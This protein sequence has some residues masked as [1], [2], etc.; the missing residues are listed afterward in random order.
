M[1]DAEQYS[2][3]HGSENRMPCLGK[4]FSISERET[5]V[6]TP[7]GGMVFI[8]IADSI[9]SG[10][11]I[12]VDIKG[13]VDTPYYDLGKTTAE[14][15]KVAKDA[16]GVFAEIRTPYL[17][18]I[19]PT[20]F[21]RHIED[22]QKAAEFWTNVTALS[23]TAMGLENRTTPM[24]M[25]FDQY[26][27]VGIAYANVWGWSCN[28]PPE[29]AK[30][31]FDY[32]G[33]VKNGSWG[34]IHEINHHYQR[35]Y[36]NYSDEWGLGTDFTEITN[37][38]LSAAS[39]ILY[40]NIAASRGEEGTYD[41]N[42]VADP[43]SSL[44][45]QIY[46]GVQYYPGVP[47]IGNFMFS[48]FAHEIG[49]INYVNVIKSTY[50]GGTFNG[51]YIPPYDYRLESQG[52]LKRDD[53]YDDMAYR[54]CM[55]GGRD[56]TWYIQ[57]ELRW[58]L[59]QETV[60]A[61][62]DLGYKETIPVQ[63]VYAMGEVGRETGRPFYIPSSGYTFDF[64]KSLVSPGDVTVVD[65]S[66]TK[67][68]TLQL[69]PD[70]K[71]DYL[72]STS[73]P[74]NA[75]DEFVLTVKVEQD[76]IS[77]ETKLNC[78][79]ALDYNASVVEHFDILKWDIYEAL[80][81]LPQNTPYGSST[82]TGMRI[83][84]A[85]GDRLSRSKGYFMVDE[86]GEYEFQAFGDDRAAFQ[87]HLDDGTTL[88]SITNDYANSAD[89]ALKLA[90]Q[91]DNKGRAK[92]TTFK[93]TLE[94]NKAYPYTL[95]AKN[96]GGIGWADVN[97]R[98][99]SGDTSW[100][101]ITKVYSNSNDI[102]K[103]TDKSF[104]MPEPEYV[105]PSYLASGDEYILKDVSVISTP[106]GVIPNDDPKSHNEGIKE[107]IVDGD[108]S[109]YFHS[110]YDTSNQTPFP[111]EY[112]FDLGGEKSFNNIEIFTRTYDHIGVIG[113]YE[114]YTADNYDG[115]NTVWTKIT[116]DKT[117]NGSSPAD[118]KLSLQ[119]VKAR[120]L[121]IKALNNRDGYD[122]TILAEV[123]VSN[124]T[125]VKNV[126]AQD[127][128][129]I[130]YEGDWKKDSNGAFVNGGTYNSTTG[131]FMYCFEGNESNIYV[132]KDVE[133]EIRVDGG[134][135]ERVKLTG[136][137]REP[138]AT[139]NMPNEGKHV[140][141]VRAINE[142][143][144]LNMISTDGVFYK[145]QAPKSNPP[146]IHGADNIKIGVGQV[147]T[148]DKMKG[149]SYTDDIDTTGLQINVTGELG[150]P[151]L[152]TNKEYTLT[153]TVTD[154]DRNTT[155]V[156][157][158]VT[159]TNQLPEIKGLDDIVINEG[160]GSGFDF[161]NGVT[162]TDLEDG[163]ITKSIQIPTMDLSSL[164]E[165]DYSVEYT[166]TDSDK[167]TVIVSRKVIVLKNNV[168]NV[169]PEETPDA[170]DAPGETPDVKPEAPIVSENTSDNQ[171][172]SSNITLQQSNKVNTLPAT[173]NVVGSSLLASIGRLLAGV[174]IKLS[175]KK[176]K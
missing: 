30:D 133:V 26:I 117:R 74:E 147:A 108:I 145:G 1:V 19:L 87:L 22:P 15:W 65:V 54:F 167:N 98:R 119:P 16:P 94:A 138:S 72:A 169:K 45:Q 34:I 59:K 57:N 85:D 80:D 91:T 157:R 11:N 174:G 122:I 111:H 36:N 40:T 106:K 176:R 63:S 21:I 39:Y 158:I 62:K 134:K 175:K 47:N 127:S 27:T 151:T 35:R 37:N 124:K 81:V 166:V 115:E 101:S 5:K 168:D 150:E 160:E 120:Y 118:I 172:Q 171:H 126:I 152:G 53:R 12:E 28:L 44:K 7:F 83:T 121:K 67:Y 154:S 32:D 104:T 116:E 50:E 96:T 66:Q 131:Y 140:V 58:P 123:K 130:Q 23:A 13:V 142:E 68:G 137:L 143:I 76:G 173:G 153:Y 31:A 29:W 8:E 43:Y 64:Q 77:H 102:G 3:N 103:V 165:G 95:I 162:V 135:W 60:K 100:K 61:I 146:V 125:N 112:I 161:A 82:S 41:W 48:T 42:K 105:R 149:V 10:T 141:E 164:T 170:P 88:Q 78:T 99:T 114:I 55:A 2:H 14:E 136:L 90:Q 155:N 75:L 49:P 69:R 6:G 93:V 159:V 139:L 132:A 89:N 52:G 56:Y 4:R 107:N 18:F 20:K 73:M 33:V 144:A 25:T 109:T 51:I 113:N 9:P 156:D 97:I 24:T 79:I 148:F 70:G 46:E 92:S 86:A 38:A 17:R 128:S 163:N 84:S 129:F 110:S 71:Y